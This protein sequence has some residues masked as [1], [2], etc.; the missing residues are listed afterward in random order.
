MEAALTGGTIIGT[1]NETL[2]ANGGNEVYLVL[3]LSSKTNQL[4][5]RSA[6]V[7][8]QRCDLSVDE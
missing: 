8:G 5:P 2:Q 1:L 7:N 4:G 6:E 3:T